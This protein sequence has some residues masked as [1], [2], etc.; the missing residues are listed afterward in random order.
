[1]K[2]FI[3]FFKKEFL[4]NLRTSKL[5]IMGV[6]F[7]GFG[8]MNPAIAKLTPALMEAM[9]D[10]L[11]E[12]GMVVTTV[13]VDALTSWT[14]FFKNIPMALIAF[15]LIYGSTFTKEY[16]SGTLVLILTKGLARYKVVLAKT[17]MMLLVW[18]TGY[19][20]CFG[21]T[22]MYNAFYWDNDLA[23]GLLPASLNW[24]L[25]GVMVVSLIVFLSTLSNSHVG[26]LLC[27]GGV[28][29]VSYMLSL[30]PELKNYVPTNLMNTSE[31][32]IGKLEQKNFIETIL[33]TIF[34]IIVSLA[35]SIPIMNKKQL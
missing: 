35:T 17:L 5:L 12:S 11:A 26:V 32:M 10:N 21:V 4:E 9:S 20:F 33:V 19:W 7:L 6:L 24:W 30:I 14:Q 3:A 8:I 16:E 1:M 25:F 27:T 18:T 13:T 34:I 22:Y 28:V 2:T 29:F 15:V 23:V 31:L